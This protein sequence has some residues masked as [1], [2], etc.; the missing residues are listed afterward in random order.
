MNALGHRLKAYP[1][2]HHLCGMWKYF[3]YFHCASSSPSISVLAL[4]VR[5]P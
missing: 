3:K 4:R 1:Q 2:N 5:L